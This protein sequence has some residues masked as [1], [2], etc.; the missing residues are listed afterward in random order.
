[1]LLAQNSP[2]QSGTD[3]FTI[4]TEPHKWNSFFFQT[5]DGNSDTNSITE[6]VIL[7]VNESCFQVNIPHLNY[8]YSGVVLKDS[9]HRITLPYNPRFPADSIVQ[10]GIY[11]KSN[12]PVSV[13]QGTSLGK[14]AHPVVGP[15]TVQPEANWSRV[16]EAEATSVYPSIRSTGQYLFFLNGSYLYNLCGCA[17]GG[18]VALYSNWDNTI[19]FTPNTELSFPLGSGITMREKDTLITL[20]FTDNSIWMNGMAIQQNSGSNLFNQSTI[21]QNTNDPIKSMIFNGGGLSWNLQNFNVIG[22]FFEETKPLGFGGFDFH[23]PPLQGNIGNTYSLHAGADSTVFRIN[24]GNPIRLDSLQRFDTCVTGPTIIRSNNPLYGYMGPCSDLSFNN[25]GY[26]PFSVT[27][28]ADTELMTESLFATFEEPDTNNHYALSVVLPTAAIPGFLLNGQN[29]P[30]NVFQAFPTEPTWSFAQFDLK[31]GV[32]KVICPGGF[33]GYHYTWYKDST[34]TGQF[35]SYGYNLAQSVVWPEDSLVP[36]GGTA[37]NDLS[38][39]DS[40]TIALCPGDSFYFQAPRHRHT[41]W[42]W[43]LGNGQALR[44]VSTEHPA[45]LQ[46]YSW[47]QPGN[48]WLV[49]SDSAG[50][51]E[52]DSLLISVDGSPDA[53]FSH[54]VQSSCAGRHILLSASNTNADSYQ[55]TWP[56]G[57]ATGPSAAIA[58]SGES[59]SLRVQLRVEE[60]G[61]V[62][63]SSSMIILPPGAAIPA[64]LP[65]VITPNGDGQNDAFVFEGIEAFEGCYSLKVFNRWGAL[66]YQSQSINKPF[67]GLDQNG[68]PLSQGVY[69][70]RLTLGEEERQGELHLFR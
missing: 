7:G 33:H 48:Y 5:N 36:F 50:C 62:D 68:R 39:W 41:T 28:N 32:H 54:D 38:P 3:F 43:D 67:T 49:L 63:S 25:N 29:P 1:M 65:N 52:G 53:R 57:S 45:P 66:V 42:R 64:Q 23:S 40:L 46:A 35:P 37:P 47:D 4:Y 20:N 59:D 22:Y 51:A 9:A 18:S 16:R 10:N 21:N 69:F 17:S 27:L 15:L 34:T 61:C 14:V 55:W 60:A 13:V 70:F 56:G 24:G 58:Y 26:S 44:Q 12:H 8:Q 19:E 31:P 30:L 11:I 2:I 6:L